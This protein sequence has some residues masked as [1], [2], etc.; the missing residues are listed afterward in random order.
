[1]QEALRREVSLKEERQR[2][3]ILLEDEAIRREQEALEAA[4]RNLRSLVDRQVQILQVQ[5]QRLLIY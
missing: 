1:M 4:H 5:R 3:E 2:F